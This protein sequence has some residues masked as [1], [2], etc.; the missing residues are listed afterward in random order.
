MPVPPLLSHPGR[1]RWDSRPPFCASGCREDG[2]ESG[3][4]LPQKVRQVPGRGFPSG[5]LPSFCGKRPWL[6]W[7]KV[8][9]AER[10]CRWT[11]GT[12]AGSIHRLPMTPFS[13]P[14]RPGRGSAW[15]HRLINAGRRRKQREQSEHG[16]LSP[17]ARRQR[18]TSHGPAHLPPPAVPPA[19][20]GAP[21]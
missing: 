13:D 17:G 16:R 18:P 8:S 21:P 4:D 10:L 3:G 19:Q 20:P 5:R 7:A 14:S 2:S 6:W 15:A 12:T 9:W 11:T 1:G